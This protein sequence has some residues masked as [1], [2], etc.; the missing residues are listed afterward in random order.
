[1]RLRRV[2]ALG[3]EPTL[4]AELRDAEVSYTR[5]EGEFY[6]PGQDDAGAAR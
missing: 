3:A 1:M 2:E 5:G 6:V 4:W